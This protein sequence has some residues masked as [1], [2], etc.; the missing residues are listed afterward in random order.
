MPCRVARLFCATL[1]LTFA[2]AA[3]AEDVSSEPPA[4]VSYVDGGA[5]LERDG[6]P[7]TSL[8]NMPIL[9]GDRIRTERGRV[10]VLFADG[11][12]LHL[13]AN[14]TVDFQSDELVRLLDGRVRLSIPG[15]DRQVNYRVDAR[16]RLG[17]YRRSPASTACR[18]VRGDRD[19]EVELM[20]LRGAA[21]L[22]NDQGRTPLRA[23]QR[24]AARVDAAPSYAYAFNSASWDAF[25]RWSEARRD[26]RLGVSTPV[27]A[28]GGAPV[29]RVVGRRRRL[30][31]RRIVRL[32]LV[33]DRR[34]RVATVPERPLGRPPSVRLDLGRC[35]GVGLAD[36]PLWTLGLLG[37]C[38][39]L[40]PRAEAGPR[41][42]YRGP[43]RPDTSAGVRSAGTT[44]P[45]YRS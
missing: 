26:Q 15:P 14:T 20:V 3:A 22:V 33:S 13:D 12:T 27:P 5:V 11:S 43:T 45:S 25:D 38:L 30:A 31:L 7:D 37:R 19:A 1:L 21:E 32:R 40:D 44:A 23:G 9:A 18:C 35:G 6:Q 29:R 28:R 41:R 24:A 42:G 34:R 8:E 10:E 4:H 39:V 17:E 36:A 2:T 16:R